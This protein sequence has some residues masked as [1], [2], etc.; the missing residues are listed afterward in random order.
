MIEHVSSSFVS[1]Y[2]IE[3]SIAALIVSF[4]GTLVHAARIWIVFFSASRRRRRFCLSAAAAEKTQ[5]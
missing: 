4:Y 1:L 2:E 3:N 5:G